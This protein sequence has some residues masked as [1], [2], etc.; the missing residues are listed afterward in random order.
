MGEPLLGAIARHSPIFYGWFIVLMC[1][2]CQ[3]SI[4]LYV[5]APHPLPEPV[6]PQLKLS[7]SPVSRFISRSYR[8]D[9]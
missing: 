1:I 8:R 5:D 7:H 4:H 6:R 3:L 9:S 2:C